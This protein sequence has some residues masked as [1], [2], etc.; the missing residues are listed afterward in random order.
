M[1]KLK[2]EYCSHT[3]IAILEILPSDTVACHSN[4]NATRFPIFVPCRISS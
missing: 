4:E 2:H 3:V 1:Q